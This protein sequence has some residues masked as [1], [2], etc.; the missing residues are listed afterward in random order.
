M[1]RF[2]PMN[3]IAS[4]EPGWAT[5]GVWTPQS[6]SNGR[7]RRRAG[8]CRPFLTLMTRVAVVADRSI[9]RPCA[10]S[11]AMVLDLRLLVRP[12]FLTLHRRSLHR[13][14]RLLARSPWHTLE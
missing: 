3:S 14:L 10:G 1:Y 8:V 11:G 6:L 13:P 2:A 5:L 9:S 12:A 4:F 7:E